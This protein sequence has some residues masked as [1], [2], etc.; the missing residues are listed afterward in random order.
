VRRFLVAY[1]GLAAEALTVRRQALEVPPLE[2]PRWKYW[3][4]MLI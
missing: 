2:V 3:V 4:A 1:A